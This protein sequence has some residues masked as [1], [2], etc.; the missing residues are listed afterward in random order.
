MLVTV[1]GR[2]VL[3]KILNRIVALICGRLPRYLPFLV[4]GTIDIAVRYFFPLAN[5]YPL[6]KFGSGNIRAGFGGVGAYDSRVSDCFRLGNIVREQSGLCRHFGNLLMHG[7]QLPE[8]DVNL[9]PHFGNLLVDLSQRDNCR[10]DAAYADE[11]EC[12]S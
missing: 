3:L 8:H 2:G 6:L 5:V 11:Y 7:S 9:T 1:S 4:Y 10:Y 12:E